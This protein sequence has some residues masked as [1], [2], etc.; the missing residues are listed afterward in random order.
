VAYTP[1]SAPGGRLPHHWVDHGV[2]LLDLVGHS[3]TLID[4]KPELG[5]CARLD[6]LS[7]DNLPPLAIHRLEHPDL[8]AK[9]EADLLLVRPDQMIAWRSRGSAEI[10]PLEFLEVLRQA[11]GFYASGSSDFTAPSDGISD[12]ADLAADEKRRV[13]V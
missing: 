3:F 6:D 5:R 4:L 10:P 7:A 12:E 8:A 9:L 13:S 1:S 11:T 2:S